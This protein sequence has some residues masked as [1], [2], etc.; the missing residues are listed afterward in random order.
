MEI[1]ARDFYVKLTNISPIN[2][3]QEGY[4][5][6][7]ASSGPELL[8]RARARF[9]LKA[10]LS[11]IQL[12]ASLYSTHP[13]RIDQLMVLPDYEFIYLRMIPLLPERSGVV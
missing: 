9:G 4:K 13:V 8:V 10:D 12:W 2:S 3:K 11:Q 1:G 7:R 5:R 6:I